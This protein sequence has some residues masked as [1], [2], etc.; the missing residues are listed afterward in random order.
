MKTLKRI[1]I[2]TVCI[3]LFLILV[4]IVF[5]LVGMGVNHYAT[6]QQTTSLKETIASGI[7]DAEI[8][9]T[10]SETGN[11]SG[12]GNHVDMLSVMLVK[13]DEEL[14]ELESSLNESYPLDSWSFGI[15]ETSSVK[16]RYDESGYPSY[17]QVL[18]VPEEMQ[19]T[20]II[21]LRQSAPFADNIEGH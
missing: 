10:Y 11:T 12:T 3:P 16:S 7:P 1:G 2:I 19:N 21:Y 13:V 6:N 17:F 8:L 14:S 20:Y 4:F 15:E 18:A 9:D 5:E